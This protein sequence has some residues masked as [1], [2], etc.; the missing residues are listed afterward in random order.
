MEQTPE[1]S[2]AINPFYNISG[3]TRLLSVGLFISSILSIKLLT[4]LINF[5]FPI[6]NITLDDNFKHTILILFSLSAIYLYDKFMITN[7]NFNPL[8]SK[9]LELEEKLEGLENIVVELENE[10]ECLVSMDSMRQEEWEKM[11]R[12]QS[13]V[14]TLLKIETDKKFK[15]FNKMLKKLEKEL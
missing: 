3:K 1:T 7:F 14:Y 6:T 13:K 15:K 2:Y 8:Q 11:M 5:V 9:L 10:N 4:S 12:T